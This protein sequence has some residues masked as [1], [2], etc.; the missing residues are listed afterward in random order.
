M[1]FSCLYSDNN[2]C[3]LSVL[4]GEFLIM[5]HW[6]KNLYTLWAAEF[7]AALG[8]SFVLPFIPFYVRELGIT[9]LAEVKKWSGLIYAGPFLAATFTVPLW[10]WMG[11][12]F[13]RKAMLIR[14]LVGFAVTTFIMGF[15]QTAY[16][17]FIL[18]IIQGGVSGFIAA[19]LAIVATTTPRRYMGYAMGILQTSLT[20]GAIVGPFIGGVLADHIGYRNIFFVTAVFGGAATFL[21]ILLVQEDQPSPEESKAPGFFSNFRF[22]FASPTLVTIFVAGMIAQ[23]ALMA[24]QPVLS[25]FVEKLWGK[26]ENLSTLAGG[27]F[28][29]TGLASL[30]A[31][32]FWGRRSDK[33]GYKKTLS[34]NLLWAGITCAPQAFVQQVSQLFIIRFVHGLFIGGVL[35][36]LNTLTTLNSPEDRRGGVMGI[37]RSGFLIGNVAGPILGGYLGASLGIPPIFI[38][39]AALLLA[40]TFA[41]RRMINEPKH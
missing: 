37:I 14:A 15:A 12:R 22:V 39:T 11:D 2:L 3:A 21:V 34:F 16:Q 8:M 30:L 40:V 32:P 13:G 38:F 7:L 10:G 19:T 41:G 6:R 28:A 26:T 4:C 9:D 18:R 36:A 24:I 27:I 20:T 31:A 33:V 35:P 1:L 5:E 23:T 25:L 29:I 17:L